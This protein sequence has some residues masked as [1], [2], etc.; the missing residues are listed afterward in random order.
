MP[1]EMSTKDLNERLALIESMIAEGR[2]KTQSWGWTFLL[3]GVAYYVAIA[4]ATWGGS[5]WAWP[6]TMVAAAILTVVLIIRKTGHSAETTVG[7]AVGSI[8]F[9]LG[10]SMFLLFLSLGMTAR[11]TDA[12]LFIAIAAAMLGMANATSAL[13][14]RWKLQFGNAVI[15]WAAAVIACFV[16][17]AQ[18]DI[19]FLVAIFFCQIVFGI[20][21]MIREGRAK[22]R[23]G[24]VHA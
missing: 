11:L 18:A 9:A 12:R 24:A 8:W 16:S 3:W 21:G 19:A 20:Y 4:W 13:V 10:V 7:R 5:P 1:E 17:E 6:V 22:A 15:W 23:R 2:R 14:L